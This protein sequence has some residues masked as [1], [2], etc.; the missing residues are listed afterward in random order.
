MA[1]KTDFK[2]WIFFIHPKI[3]ALIEKSLREFLISHEGE[4]LDQVDATVF[5]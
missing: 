1:C 4:T 2:F 5:K 3:E